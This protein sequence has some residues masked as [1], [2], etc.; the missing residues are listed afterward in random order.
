MN[1]HK[2]WKIQY[3]D[4]RWSMGTMYPYPSDGV[5]KVWNS[6]APVRSHIT[7]TEGKYPAGTKVVEMVL[8][9]CGETLVDGYLESRDH[10][11]AEKAE[12][13]QERQ[14]KDKEK[15]ERD[16]LEYLRKKYSDE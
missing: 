2:V 15:A 7:S 5:G 9:P 16:A 14:R 4:G 13:G 10:L 1:E 12:R 11:A 8:T 6:L 3:P